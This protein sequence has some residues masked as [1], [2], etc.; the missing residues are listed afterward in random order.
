MRDGHGR[1]GKLNTFLRPKSERGVI[2]LPNDG[3]MS[4]KFDMR[5]C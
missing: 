5:V 2:S 4:M 1:K 3:M